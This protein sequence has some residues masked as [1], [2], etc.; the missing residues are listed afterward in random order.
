MGYVPAR[1]SMRFFVLSILAAG[2]CLAPV[3]S[4]AEPPPGAVWTEEYITEADGT[5]LH[6][7]VLRPANLPADAKTPVILSIG[8]YFNHSGQVGALG[9]VQGASYTPTSGGPSERFYDFIEGAQ[10]LQKGYTFVMVDLRGFGGST[11]CLDWSGP[12]EQ[13]DVV[14][15]VEWAASQ[16]WSTG[17]VGM[18][19][20][21]YDAVTGMLG[22]ALKPRGLNAVVAQEPV[23]DM[24]RYL[25]ANG[26][27]YPNSV[28]T[29]LLYDAIAASPG[30]TADS[31][32]YVQNSLD[33]TARPGCPVQS[34]ADQQN[35]DRSSE[36]WKVRNLITMSQ[37]TTVPVFLT[38]GFLE[39]NTKPDGT[40]DYFNGLA[41][42]KRAWFGMWDHVRGN[43]VD[44][45]GRLKMGRATWFDE[46]MRFY[47]QHLKGIEPTVADAPVVVQTSDGNWRAEQ[48]W[49]PADSRDFTTALN[50]GAYTDHGMNNGT[51]QGYPETGDGVWTFSPPVAHDAHFA[52]VPRV[53]LDVETQ[54]PDANLVVNLYD[55][56][57]ENDATL[58]SRET[59]LVPESG[60]VE[61]PLY[62]NDWIVKK[63]HRVGVLVTSSNAEWWLHRPTGQD[64]AVS[65]A[66][67]A[68]PFKTCANRTPLE[69]DPSVKLESYLR[70]APFE[71][72]AETVQEATNP[73]FALP[74][75][76]ADCAQRLLGKRAKAKKRCAKPR[77]G[78][79]TRKQRARAMKRYRACK[80]SR[81]RQQSRARRQSVNR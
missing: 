65:A 76:V 5:K 63:D 2:A 24:Y 39:D 19:G 48:Q 16:P 60:R 36:Y 74:G 54:A 72:D 9:P 31:P 11:G 35:E 79:K 8:P 1:R 12:G 66:Q 42:P 41:G 55:L 56:D 80:R 10:V 73:A 64:V 22:A 15:A 7:D 51:E 14:A 68:I 71:V 13:A 62:G 32:E 20:K 18:Y 75:P 50:P 33:D 49:P 37:G 67:I 40:W 47:D 38:Q 77:L 17:K 70:N 58:I 3:A 23:Y 59:Y 27:R 46:V 45:E 81:A 30:S 34:W 43:E 52:G 61:F 26:V 28:L 25:Y 44:D 4:A 29:P 21:S 78:G 53:A 6:V 57:G 69:G